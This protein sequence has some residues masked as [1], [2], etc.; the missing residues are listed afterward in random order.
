[1]YNY[2]IPG[3]PDEYFPFALTF[4][5][6]LG[7]LALI[8]I[9][10]F[11]I[12]RIIK[13]FKSPFKYPYLICN[14]DVSGRRNPKIEDYIDNYLNEGNLDY[15]KA[16]KQ[17]IEDWKSQCAEKIQKSLFKNYRQRQFE[18]CLD[19]SNAFQFN[20]C[21]QQTR[22]RQ[23]N[24]QRTPYKVSQVVDSQSHD[25]DYL[26]NRYFKLAVTGH[27]CTL[28]EYHSKNQRRL[29]TPELRR[30]IMERDNYTC[31]ICGKYMPDEVGLHIDHKIPVSKGGKTIPSNLQVLCS[32]C[33]GSKSN[34]VNDIY[35]S[36]R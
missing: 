3:V 1:M 2:Y 24:Y 29:M 7:A 11:I 35:I 26:V 4:L 18:E 17:Y 6:C 33:N 30:K 23:R 9:I 25:Y 27:E 13:F 15:I 19:D 22:Y 21:R 32:K 10:A 36:K 8:G 20:L 31:Q 12:N 34:S 5:V 28:N 14:F 16:R